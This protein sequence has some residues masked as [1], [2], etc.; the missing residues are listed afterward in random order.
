MDEISITG[1]ALLYLAA[2][3]GAPEIWGIADAF[4]GETDEEI[5]QDT[6]LIQDRLID[7]NYA[8]LDF[9]GEFQANEELMAAVRVCAD[10]DRYISTEIRDRATV[11]KNRL[12]F[13]KDGKTIRIQDSGDELTLYAMEEPDIPD[14]I[15]GLYPN[16]VFLNSGCKPVSISMRELVRIKKGQKEQEKL[17]AR[18]CCEQMAS[19]LCEGLLENAVLNTMVVLKRGSGNIELKSY[20]YAYTNKGTILFVIDD[21]NASDDVWIEPVQSD[22]WREQLERIVASSSSEVKG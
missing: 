6:R 9:N 5:I 7:Q 11:R 13:T 2:M 19:A 4:Y 20:S 17:L 1:K 22:T 15:M 18:G 10:F 8:D 12:F 3:L 14:E 21:D 16:P